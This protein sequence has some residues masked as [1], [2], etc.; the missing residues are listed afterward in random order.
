MSSERKIDPFAA[1]I[2]VTS[3]VG[4]I[5]VATQWFASLWTGAYYYHSCLDCEN[6]TP[7]D[8]TSQ[9]LI[10]V[11]FVC[12][13]VVSLNDLLPKRFIQRDLALYGLILAGFTVLFAII[14]IVLFGTY[15]DAY[16]WW[17]DT[18]FYGAIIP[19]IINIILFFLKFKNR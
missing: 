3:I 16:E 4:I 1:I 6:A 15:W 9:I 12:Q 19:G 7:G 13:I 17:P 14:G 2:L 5:L 11:F 18:G 8:L 10:L